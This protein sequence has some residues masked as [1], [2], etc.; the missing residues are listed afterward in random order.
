VRALRAPVLVSDVW[1]WHAA[2]IRYFDVRRYESAR[3]FLRLAVANG[4]SSVEVWRLKAEVN[5]LL[6][7]DGR[8]QGGAG[9][10]RTT[11]EEKQDVD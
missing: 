4:A 5:V 9:E 2:A 6:H 3:K 8:G 7:K 1:V 11:R 10:T